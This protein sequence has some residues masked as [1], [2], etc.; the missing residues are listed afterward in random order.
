MYIKITST[1]LYFLV[2]LQG[3]LAQST[4]KICSWN[5]ANM[6]KSKDD[7]EI[8]FMAKTIKEFDII[9]IQEVSTGP[10]GAKA[11]ARLAD[12]L[13]R[14]GDAWDYTVSHPTSGEGSERYAYIWRKSKVKIY[15]NPFLEKTFS[16]CINREPFMARFIIRT[17]T[18]LV[19]NFHAV[20][21]TKNPS[22]EIK[23]LYKIPILY[24]NDH[25]FITGDFNLSCTAP[26]YSTLYQVQMKDGIN[27]IKTT[28]KM[29]IKN[30]EKFAN[31]YDHIFYEFK[32]ITLTGS[33]RID[34]TPSFPTLKDCR[35][36]SD[37]VPV[38]VEVKERNVIK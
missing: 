10:E 26:I 8:S 38:W 7:I 22:E 1:V 5:I 17:D 15:G 11:V 27:N 18:V 32:E 4:Y 34:F 21:A 14:R 33:G 20:P 24:P 9:S 13:N 6:G 35:K 16:D 36:I 3:A 19:A 2:V 12:E 29:E 30:N 23:Y 28:L 37:H 25:L 31:P